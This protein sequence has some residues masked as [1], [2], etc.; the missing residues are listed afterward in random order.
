[1]RQRTEIFSRIKERKYF[2]HR[3]SPAN[4]RAHAAFAGRG[5]PQKICR[6]SEQ[7]GA[8]T[9][10]FLWGACPAHRRG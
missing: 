9:R 10:R 6:P 3:A 7:I 4:S 1:M 8:P 5:E 2:R